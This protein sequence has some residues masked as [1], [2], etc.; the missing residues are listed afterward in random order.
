[1]RGNYGESSHLHLSGNLRRALTSDAHDR[2]YVLETAYS[3]GAILLIILIFT[4]AVGCLFAAYVTKSWYPSFLLMLPSTAIFAFVSA[5]LAYEKQMDQNGTSE[6][7]IIFLSITVLLSVFEMF[8]QRPSCLCASTM[9]ATSFLVIPG[10]VLLVTYC[11]RMNGMS[12]FS[13]HGPMRIIGYSVEESE[14]NVSF[15]MLPSSLT[16]Y[17]SY[18]KVGWGTDWGCPQYRN[19]WCESVTQV[20]D[21]NYCTGEGCSPDGKQGNETDAE[22]CVGALYWD[23]MLGGN[24]SNFDRNAIPE[25][26]SETWPVETFYGDC[27]SCK[28]IEPASRNKMQAH[29]MKL[30]LAGTIISFSGAAAYF[31]LLVIATAR[32][33]ARR[34]VADNTLN[35]DTD[36]TRHDR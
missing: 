19:K 5:Q 3:T 4:I 9:L 34:R 13:Y 29:I 28:V 17:D 15:G 21:C 30:K 35:P 2:N 33:R 18:R 6:I 7:G 25:E 20:S 16:S 10:L 14:I 27:F 11:F 1:M 12:A 36:M 23:N 22:K 26:G 32:T 8:R 31:I 24:Y